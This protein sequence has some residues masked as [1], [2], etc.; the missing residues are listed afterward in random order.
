[1]SVRVRTLS[2]LAAGL[3]AG[4]NS[5]GEWPMMWSRSPNRAAAVV[6]AHSVRSLRRLYWPYTRHTADQY[7]GG[8]MQPHMAVTMHT[9]FVHTYKG[10]GNALHGMQLQ[11]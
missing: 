7:T 6:A 5:G 8:T 9:A 3:S 10:L 2:L 4:A 11:Q 1:M